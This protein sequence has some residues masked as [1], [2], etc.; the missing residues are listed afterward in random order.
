MWGEEPK[1]ALDGNA[2]GWGF[3][4]IIG[5]VLGSEWGCRIAAGLNRTGPELLLEAS[6]GFSVDAV[7]E[8]GGSVGVRL[9]S[10]GGVDAASTWFAVADVGG[11]A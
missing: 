11:V 6:A 1:F 8:F 10:L 3:R 5:R 7:L 2:N 9:G 4:V